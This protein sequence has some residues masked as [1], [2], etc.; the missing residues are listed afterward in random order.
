MFPEIIES[1][2]LRFEPRTTDYV[3]PLTAYEFCKEGAPGIDEVTRYVP[4]EPHPHPKETLDFLERGR[5]K[6]DD[7]EEAGYVIRLR[8]PEAEDDDVGD[9]VG[10][11]G[12][13]L[14]WKKRTAT[15]GLWVRPQYWGRGYSG[16]R[17]IAL[18]SLAFDRLDL[19]LLSVTHQVDNEQSERAI[20]K[21]VERMG[22]RREG[23]LRNIGTGRDGPVDEVRYSVSQEEWNTAALD[24]DVTFHDDAD[25]ADGAT[26]PAEAP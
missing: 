10:F 11:T 26:D 24:P 19:D 13:N 2:R 12:A 15:L 8:T 7:R 4:W 14:D 21:Y 6:W 25:D 9:I 22:G 17:A 18:A 1:R 23:T 5:K 3:D 20:T 16:E